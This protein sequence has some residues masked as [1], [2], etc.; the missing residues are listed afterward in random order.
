M[1][2]KGLKITSTA[3]ALILSTSVNASNIL[4]FGDSSSSQTNL[5]SFL[6]SQ[7]HS[8]TNVA[9][10]S[11]PL[12]FSGYDT[13]WSLNIHSN[14]DTLINPLQDFLD[15]GKGIYFTGER[16]CCDAANTTIQT[17]LNTNVIGGG[18]TVGS[19]GDYGST[20]TFN[21]SATGNISS[22]P[23]N[24]TSWSPN[25][26]GGIAGVTGD[27]IFAS[28]STGTIGAV[29]DSSDLVNQTGRIAVLM[30]ANWFSSS[31]IDDP[32]IEN[33]ELFLEGAAPV[34]Q[35]PIPAAIWLFGSGLI[36]LIGVA[37]RKKA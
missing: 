26:S 29:F 25:A 12:D 8:V 7:G 4:V 13:I 24:L 27:N 5:T 17:F 31:T 30:D 11:V 1:G 6:V 22:Y 10:G 23:N 34:S 32:I 3:T 21:S 36:G 16:P 18:I 14:F 19:L 2:I 35:V 33:I 20:A 9:T 15:S 28:T 37:R